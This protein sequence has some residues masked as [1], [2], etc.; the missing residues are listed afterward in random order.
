MEEIPDEEKLIA[1]GDYAKIFGIQVAETF[2]L[3]EGV[4]VTPYSNP[5]YTKIEEY[6]S[7]AWSKTKHLPPVTVEEGKIQVYPKRL[8]IGQHYPISILGTE[9]LAHKPKEGTIDIYEVVK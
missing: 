6:I 7:G 9:Y 1:N 2:S 4:R 3:T 5:L 8:K